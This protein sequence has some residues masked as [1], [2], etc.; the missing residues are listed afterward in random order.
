MNVARVD[1]GAVSKARGRLAALALDPELAGQSGPENVTGWIDTMVKHIEK[2]CQGCGIQFFAGRRDKVFHSQECKNDW[3]QRRL[4]AL[5]APSEL[6]AALDLALRLT[7]ARAPEAVEAR[8]TVFAL[9]SA[10]FAPVVA[11]PTPANDRTD[12]G[13]LA[14][15]PHAAPTIDVDK[16]RERLLR[17]FAGDS[18]PSQKDIAKAIGVDQGSLSRFIT[19]ARTPGLASL[20]R[21]AIWLDEYEGKVKPR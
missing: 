18:H 12:A 4:A 3:H 7:R 5:K 2:T 20:A 10:E 8:R 15:T 1:F 19:G 17:V 14:A 11:S 6:E 16:L 21:I 9:L 13:E